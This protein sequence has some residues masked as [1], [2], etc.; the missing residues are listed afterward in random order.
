MELIEN[1]TCLNG[2]E[3][4]ETKAKMFDEIYI[5]AHIANWNCDNPHTDWADHVNN[6]IEEY[7]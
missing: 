5:I 6:L 7:K 1:I 2:Y 4:D 3:D